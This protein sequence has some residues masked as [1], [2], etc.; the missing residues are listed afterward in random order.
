MEILF[1][2]VLIVGFLTLGLYCTKSSGG[3]S[4]SNKYAK[5]KTEEID[6]IPDDELENAAI[7]WLF[8][9]L[10]SKGTT[11]VPIMRAMSEP[12]RY[13]YATYVV[14]GEV[15]SKGMGECFLYVD[16]YLLSSAVE[17]FLDMGAE[18]LAGILEKACGVAGKFIAENGREN[19]AELVE[20][21]E[22]KQLSEQFETN[23]EIIKLP[24][25]IINYIKQNKEYFG[26]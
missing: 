18:H 23:E 13:V 17:G 12:C 25:I 4:Y 21:T 20:N 15:M 1:L 3:E 7:D 11:E 26:D 19:L 24:D 16:S 10:D 8:S 14:T 9:K 22:L 2:V 6:S 5:L